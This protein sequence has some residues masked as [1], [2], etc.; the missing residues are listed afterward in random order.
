KGCTWINDRRSVGEGKV[1]AT[2]HVLDSFSA[3]RYHPPMP[4][5]PKLTP[6]TPDDL[7]QALAHGLRFNGRKHFHQGDEL[8]ARITA[9]HLISRAT[10]ASASARVV[11]RRSAS[12]CS[13]RATACSSA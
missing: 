11:F 8:M 4:D 5:E 3:S 6:A 2:T 12:N 1:P 7:A 10:V 9:E 13:R